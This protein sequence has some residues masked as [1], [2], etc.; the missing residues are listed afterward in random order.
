VQDSN[1]TPYAAA[2]LIGRWR[3]IMNRTLEDT[4]ASA[5]EE[6]TDLM[7]EFVSPGAVRAVQD[8]ASE[9]QLK[10]ADEAVER[11]VSAMVKAST[12]R[13]DGSVVVE[14]SAIEPAEKAICPVYPFCDR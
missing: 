2:R 11:F 10:K 13:P 5:A 1:E 14:A 3:T 4:R 12:R 8:K 9:A 6:V 7:E